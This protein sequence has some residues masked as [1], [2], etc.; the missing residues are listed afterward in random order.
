MAVPKSN[1]LVLNI[2]TQ[3]IHITH[4]HVYSISEIALPDQTIQLPV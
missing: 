3:S 2:I 1:L 4:R